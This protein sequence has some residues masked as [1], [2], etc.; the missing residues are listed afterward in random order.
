M[1]D[2]IPA[3]NGANT[4]ATEACDTVDL[5]TV[6]TGVQASD[7]A[8]ATNAQVIRLTDCADG[9]G[10]SLSADVLAAISTNEAIGTVLQQ[11][12]VAAGEIAGLSVDGQTVLIYVREDDN[13]SGDTDA[14][15]SAQ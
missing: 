5:G 12:T 1:G 15:T 9:S 8:A 11:E 10:S 6:S 14:T 13:S 3:A 4:L 2:C 7:I